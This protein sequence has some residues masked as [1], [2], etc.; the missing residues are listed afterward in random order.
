MTKKSF[1][2]GRV[3]AV[4]AI[5][6]GVLGLLILTHHIASYE[7]ILRPR[8]DYLISNKIIT[9]DINGTTFLYFFTNQSNIFVDM[10]LIL[11]GIGLLGN[12]KL[13]NFTHN[14]T[15]RGGITLYIL[16]TGIIYCCVLLPFSK[17]GYPF[18]KSIWF[19]NIVNYWSHMITPAVMTAFWFVPVNKK[20]IHIVKSSLLYLIYPVLYFVFSIIRG[21]VVNFYPY[22]FLNGRQMWT[23]IFAD[24]EYN[25][26]IGILL[27]VAVVVIFSAMFFGIGC[28]LN[29][30]HNATV[31]RSQVKGSAGKAKQHIA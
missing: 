2:S 7:A 24:K 11:F 21:A 28:G 31:N 13:Y 26:T 29:K 19:S 17:G 18:E 9:N 3:F 8:M 4:I 10:F 15:L 12:K 20:P 14:E 5:C 23:F 25:G 22:P 1:F 30:I 16:F 6:Y 27:L